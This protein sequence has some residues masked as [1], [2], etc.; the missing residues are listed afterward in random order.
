MV[1]V[2]REA[3]VNLFKFVIIGS[4]ITQYDV[5]QSAYTTLVTLFVAK[6]V[7]QAEESQPG[8]VTRKTWAGILGKVF[9]G[10]WVFR[11]FLQNYLL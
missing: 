4:D 10:F 1:A 5:S 3:V 2:S 7:G 6:I 11:F 8:L 9:S